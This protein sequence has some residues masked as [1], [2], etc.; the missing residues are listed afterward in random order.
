[1]QESPFPFEE[2]PLF[3]S[4]TPDER[5]LLRERV[6]L[7]AF[8]PQAHL[9]DSGQDSPGLYTI[10]S[11]LVA[12]LVRDDAGHERELDSLGKGECVGEMALMT[13]EP[14]S[15]TVR[16]ITDTEAW[17]IDR[18]DFLDL[19][20]RCPGLWRNLGRIL[21]QRLARTSRHL[22]AQPSASTVVLM[23]AC[24]E[25]EAAALAVA[26]AASL[27]R[28]TG[29]RTLLVDACA[30]SASPAADFAPGKRMPSLW[31][32]L[33]KRSLLKAHEA[34][35]DR[36]DRLRGARVASLGDEEGQRPTVEETLTVLEWLRPLYDYI[37]LLLPRPAAEPWRVLLE[38]AHS[39]VTVVTE[40]EAQGGLPWLDRLCGP[41][42][43]RAKL[44]IAIVAA[45]LVDPSIR[46]AMEERLGRPVRRLPRESGLLQQMLRKKTPLTEDRP[47]LPF[48]Q[49]VDRL[50]R[51]IGGMEVGLALGGGAA[52]GFAHVGVLRVLEENGVPVDYIAGCSIG[53]IVGALYAGGRPLS[54]VEEH[55]RG[56][57]RK[58]TRWTLPFRSIWSDAGLK[59]ILRE[60]GPTVR[61][62]DLD[63][64][65][66][67]VATDIAT[68]REVVLRK[69]LVWKAVQA[70]V[71]IPGIFPP[72]SMSG[73]HLV[74]GGLV[75][76]VPSQTVRVM[77]A[78]IV[79]AVDLMSPAGRVTEDSAS[80]GGSGR[81]P[82][83]RV[84]NL[85]EML[86][87]S[88]EI[89]QEE[90]TA[91]SAATAD[92]TIEPK[93]GRVRWG[94]FSQ[95]GQDFIIAGEEAAREKLPELRR[96][97]PFATST[98]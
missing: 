39:I 59:E 10:R 51:H 14:C 42:E 84:P 4:L 6:Q 89:M 23:M 79:V 53:A 44:E 22:A 69:G 87:R 95:R 43:V 97:L 35:P 78:D 18:G 38:R 48:S 26:V 81:A 27:A 90:V 30:G 61:F 24:P 37:L 12:V 29:K 8:E 21:S 9:L 64:P 93:L 85:L 55:L 76:P 47:E 66:A 91:R 96:L 73:R 60:P 57:D 94:D 88:T 86:W 80:S 65:F 77:G 34:A 2:I 56:A 13:G 1:M 33:H 31:E 72:V 75:N 63:I 92:V 15:A 20:D 46:Q 71:S 25:E 7:R 3:Q 17:F 45:G 82:A 28:Q 74:D 50:A 36:S 52:K 67:T 83:M 58:I 98:D 41:S 5:A 49:A 16:A 70:S 68:G 54:D 19:V 40:E 32:V 11:G 62:G